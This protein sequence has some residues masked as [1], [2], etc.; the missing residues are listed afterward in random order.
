[1][2]AILSGPTVAPEV[3]ADRPDAIGGARVTGLPRR[4]LFGIRA[5][6]STKA[7]RGGRAGAYASLPRISCARG[8]GKP[9][10]IHPLV[11]L[12]SEGLGCEAQTTSYGPIRAG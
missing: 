4:R 11:Q 12:S 6:I 7:G 9:L 3:V 8:A 10:D 2:L 1:V 5:A